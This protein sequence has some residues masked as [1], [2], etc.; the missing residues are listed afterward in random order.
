MNP[1][2]N[3]PSDCSGPPRSSGN[4]RN[5]ILIVRGGA[6]GDFILTLPVL[7]AL[8]ETFPETRLEVL[9]Y[10]R[11]ADL[12]LQSGLADGIRALED[13]PVARFFARR[14][15]LDPEWQGYFGSFAIIV[16]YLF[17]PDGIFEENIKRCSRAQFIPGLHRP[18][19]VGPRHATQVLLEPLQRLAVFDAD[20]VPRLDF[21]ATTH[22]PTRPDCVELEAWVR[23]GPTLAVHP[24]SG[25][26]TKNWPSDHWIALMESVG[27]TT[28]FQVLIVGGEAE[29]DRL[30]RLA[31]ALPPSR[32]RVARSLP[33][34]A[35]GKLLARCT[36]FLGH[37]SGVSHLAAAVGCPCSILWGPTSEAVWRPMGNQVLLIKSPDG[38][39]H[40]SVSTVL[41]SLPA[42]Q[43]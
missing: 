36:H 12:A 3:T 43:V 10:P 24:G 23:Q 32:R 28:S 2:S 38:L 39:A 21:R 40:L 6:I 27:R 41:S 1:P 18:P 17:D 37:D 31:A 11:V 7:R 15:E 13:R 22:Q 35:V 9:G 8:R 25:S 42:S 4:P 5:R 34:P 29:G 14:A 19:D 20:P 30:D 26:E 33:L 16:S